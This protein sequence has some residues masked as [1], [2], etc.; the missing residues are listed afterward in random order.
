MAIAFQVVYTYVDDSGD[1]ATHAI[2]IPTTFSLAQY[3]EFGRAMAGLLDDIVHG[4]IQSAQLVI[5]VDISGL[6]SNALVAD[7]DVEELGSF[8]FD[9]G[10]GRYVLINIPAFDEGMVLAGSDNIDLSDP[11]VAAFVTA[12]ETG[13][14]VTGGTISPCDVNEDDLQFLSFAREM[15]RSSGKRR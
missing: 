9:T 15:F 3:T 5:N 13:I 12:I 14:A 8:Q 10:E 2:D 4:R 1:T 11:A 7:S 6:T